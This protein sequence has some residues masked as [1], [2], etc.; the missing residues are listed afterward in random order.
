MRKGAVDEERG[1]EG[2]REGEGRRQRGM[3]REG[4]ETE[5]DL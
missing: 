4:E 2:D 5:T 1:R 3:R